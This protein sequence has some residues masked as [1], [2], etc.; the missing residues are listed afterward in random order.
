MARSISRGVIDQNVLGESRNKPK[1][2]VITMSHGNS[3]GAA[4][5][6][7]LRRLLQ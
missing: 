6:G 3:P 7:A 2:T 1:P 5:K 4:F